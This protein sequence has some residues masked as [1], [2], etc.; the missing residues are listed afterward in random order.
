MI[1]EYDAPLIFATENN[2]C[3]KG[4]KERKT[5]KE[6]KKEDGITGRKKKE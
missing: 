5:K 3:S 6:I 1:P 4:I 2:I